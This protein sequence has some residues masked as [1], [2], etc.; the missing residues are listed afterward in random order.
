MV[1]NPLKIF[2]TAYLVV[3]CYHFKSYTKQK[4]NTYLDGTLSITH[5]ALMTFAK[6]HF[7]YLKKWANGE[8]NL[9]TTKRL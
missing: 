8:P 2:F 4:H 6:S 7:D 5:E 1:D 3:P 9:P